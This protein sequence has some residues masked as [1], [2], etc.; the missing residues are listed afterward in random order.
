MKLNDVVMV[1]PLPSVP[2]MFRNRTGKV[3]GMSL[4]GKYLDIK[5][6][7]D[8]SMRCFRSDELKAVLV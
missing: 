5:M 3:K 4:T 7:D 2:M 1:L 6:N 8:G